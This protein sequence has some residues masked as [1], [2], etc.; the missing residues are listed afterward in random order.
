[1]P[2]RTSIKLSPATRDDLRRYRRARNHDSY[3][4]AIQALLDTAPPATAQER[5]R[6]VYEILQ[7]D[8]ATLLDHLELLLEADLPD[9]DLTLADLPHIHDDAVAAHLRHRAEQARDALR[10]S[11]PDTAREECD[12]IITLATALI[13]GDRP[14]P[15]T[16]EAV[17]NRQD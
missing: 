9:T 1:V 12:R 8:R 10:R 2:D 14:D 17:R 11:D 4:D 15:G 5:A 13:D 3:D 16:P 7:S 6:G